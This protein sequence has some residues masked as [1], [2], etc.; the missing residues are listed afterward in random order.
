MYATFVCIGIM[1]AEHIQ[2]AVC[3]QLT[4]N[5]ARGGVGG[6]LCCAGMDY[7]RQLWKGDNPHIPNSHNGPND[8][9]NPTT[10]A[11]YTV[12]TACR[13]HTR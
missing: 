8:P 3:T 7:I 5:V 12:G 4:L 2:Q 11:T 9:T 10:P 1:E 13:T 6:E